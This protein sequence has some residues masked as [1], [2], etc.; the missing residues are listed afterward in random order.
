MGG[1]GAMSYAARHPDTFA[2]AASFSGAV[3]TVN[4]ASEHRDPASD[5]PYGPL[6]TQEIRW[7]GNN[8]VDLAANLRGLRPG[9]ADGQ[10]AAGRPRSA[11]ATP[12]EQV[13]HTGRA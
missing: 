6:A 10:R 5:E 11:A 1:F 4:P 13:V 3:D 8:P 2:A 7:R 9:A 12:I